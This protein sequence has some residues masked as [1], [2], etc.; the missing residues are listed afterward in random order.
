MM[1]YITEGEF[2]AGPGGG[3]GA[4]KGRLVAWGAGALGYG[5]DRWMNVCSFVCTFGR[6]DGWMDGRMDGQ[7]FPLCYMTLSPF[8]PLPKECM[9]ADRWTDRPIDQQA[10]LQK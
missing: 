9:L 5:T 8:G 7:K 3:A 6:M 2:S 4:L 1:S 10:V